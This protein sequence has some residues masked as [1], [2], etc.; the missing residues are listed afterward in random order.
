M[1]LMNTFKIVIINNKK[2]SRVIYDLR[3]SGL[4]RN[5]FD[6]PG[7]RFSSVFANIYLLY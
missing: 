2:N 6:F 7:E 1:F 4:Y 3:I 5:I